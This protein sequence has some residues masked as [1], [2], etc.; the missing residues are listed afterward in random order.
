[1]KRSLK[2]LAIAT[3]VVTFV[4]PQVRAAHVVERIIARVNSEIITQRQFERERDKLREE[5]AQ[6]YSGAD[7][8]AKLNDESKNL[9]RNLIDESLMVQKAKDEDINVD[10][11]LIKKLDQMRKQDNLAT[12]EDLQK[13]AEQQGVNWEDFKEQ[14]RRQLLMQEVI[15]REVGSRVIVTREDEKQY[16]NQHKDEFKSE[17][18]I[19][20]AEILVSTEKYKPD[21][22]EKRAKDAEAELKG[23]AKF[24]EVVKKYSDGPNADSSGDIGLM[25]TSSVAPAILAAIDKLDTNEYT[26]VLQTKNG[27]MILRLLEHF[28][29][30]VPKFEEVESHVQE[31]LYNQRMAPKMREYLNQ[32]RLDSYIFKAPGYIDTGDVT[33][34]AALTADK[35]Q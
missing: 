3:L 16:Y 7:L 31:M 4:T 10:T 18:M 21:E 20:L 11:D 32:L 8:E 29:P 23:G 25:K 13:D 14:I 30:G 28:S 12:I 5:L 6:Q 15:G 2:L 34:G 27:Y 26:D 19:H 24:S 17:G 33:P 22:A 35:T 1:M 9:L